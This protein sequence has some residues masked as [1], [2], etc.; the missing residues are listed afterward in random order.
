MWVIQRAMCTEPNLHTPRSKQNG[1]HWLPLAGHEKLCLLQ[2][3]SAS[4]KGYHEKEE[5]KNQ[6][7]LNGALPSPVGDGSSVVLLGNRIK[8]W[9]GK[10]TLNFANVGLP[11]LCSRALSLGGTVRHNFVPS[12]NS[13]LLYLSNPALDVLLVNIVL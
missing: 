11:F 9:M 4:R 10:Q 6:G 3:E 5:K 13:S 7:G 1:I 2:P 12:P 8:D